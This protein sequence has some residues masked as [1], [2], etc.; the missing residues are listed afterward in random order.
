M[1]RLIIVCLF[2]LAALF[3]WRMQPAGL[4][5]GGLPGAGRDVATTPGSAGPGAADEL[6]IE[7]V[8]TAAVAE[9]RYREIVARYGDD[10]VAQAWVADC[11]A[12]AAAGQGQQEFAD[13]WE[14]AC[15][16]SWSD[17]QDSFG[18]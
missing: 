14:Y 2:V 13:S 16:R 11:V 6:R 4:N 8:E 10:P 9:A 5:L 1:R 17:E 7:I 12:Q 15:W 3:L 18:R